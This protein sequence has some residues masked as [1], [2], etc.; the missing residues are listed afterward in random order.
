MAE[1][2][3]LNQITTAP[4]IRRDGTNLDS[5]FYTAGQWVRFQRGKPKKMGGYRQI[6]N[7]LSGPIRAVLVWSRGLLNSLYSFS[8]ARIEMLLMTNEGAGSTLYDRTPVGFVANEN[9]LWTGDTMFDAAVGSNGTVVIAVATDTLTNIDDNTLK[10]VYYGV[11]ADTTAFLPIT[12]LMVSGGV[13]CVS[14]YLIYYGSD[15]LVG[16]SDVNQP[17]TL[18]TGDAGSARVTGAKIVKVL[19]LR[20]GNGPGALLWSLDSLIAMQYVG[21]AAVFKFS[22]VSAQS[23]VLSQNGVIEYDGSYFWAGIDRF[24]A[25]SGGH[26]QEI[27]NDNNLNWF[28]DNLNFAER[29]KVWAMKVPR[30]GEIWWF[31]PR[32]EATECTHAVIFNVREKTWYDC[33]LPRSAGFYS[34]VFHYPVMASSDMD[35]RLRRIEISISSGSF[36]VGDI[37]STATTNKNFQITLDEGG[38]FFTVLLLSGSFAFIDGEGITNLTQVGTGA[39]LSTQDL[40]SAF[41]HEKGLNAVTSDNETAIPSYFETSDFGYPTGGSHPNQIEGLNRY[42]RLV[43]IEPDFIMEGD[44]T[45][46]VIGREFAQSADIV[47]S[48]F[49]FDKNTGKIDMREQRRQIRLRF[50]SN[51]SNGN[52][53][54]G[55]TILHTEPGDVRT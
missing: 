5:D 48:P 20:T 43:R 16:W 53:E 36:A 11:A 38:G 13:C 39:V 17:Q 22:T 51:T 9:Y 21:G 23:S 46:E 33:E 31:Y 37:V 3:K 26:V 30:F 45:V 28:F 4:G 14:P 27:P 52:F 40:Y 41:M 15:G 12:G 10:Q 50:T 29:Q 44:M 2:T 6:S 18:T 25:Y 8:Y 42:T 49:T 1:I 35:S 54:M 34:Q 32:G 55:R 19:P 47:S 7:A 24:L